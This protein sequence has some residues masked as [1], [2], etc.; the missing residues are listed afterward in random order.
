[1]HGYLA[2][3]LRKI[4][5]MENIIKW[6]IIT[7][8]AGAGGVVT[9]IHELRTLDKSFSYLRL[10]A[11]LI[12]S[13]FAGVVAVLILLAIG[14]DMNS[15]MLYAIAGVSGRIGMPLIIYAENLIKSKITDKLGGK[16]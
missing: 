5:D 7:F 3:L 14:T 11:D 13:V 16:I 8:I 10:I 2:D 15:Y 4:A 1:M 9:H 12:I 6:I